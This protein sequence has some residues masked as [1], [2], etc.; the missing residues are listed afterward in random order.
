MIIQ[1]LIEAKV[2]QMTANGDTFSFQHSEKDWQNLQAD[3]K[4]YPAVFLDMPVKVTPSILQGGGYEERYQCI[5]NF[6]YKSNLADNPDQQYATIGKAGEA[7]KD[8]ILL[9][10][11][12][13]DNF[14]TEKN[15]YG[16]AFQ[17]INL[18]DVNLDAMVLPFTFVPRNRPDVCL[19]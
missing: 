3:E 11:S 4:L 18:F 13:V 5:I 17:A 9:C 15:V 2:N 7:M 16:Q 6:L 8:F 12:D 10:E 14:D 19:P 1:E